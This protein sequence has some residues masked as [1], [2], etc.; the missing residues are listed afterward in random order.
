MVFLADKN[1]V[2]LSSYANA[3]IIHIKEVCRLIEIKLFFFEKNLN[4][5]FKQGLEFGFQ[6]NEKF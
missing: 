4:L 5:N 1:N 2:D 3:E 6:W